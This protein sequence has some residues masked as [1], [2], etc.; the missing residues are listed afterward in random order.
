MENGVFLGEDYFEQLLME[1]PSRLST[2]IDIVVEPGT[3]VDEYI[4]RA[5]VIFPFVRFEEHVRV[6]KNKIEK[7]H[8]Q[9]TQ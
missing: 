4:R 2:D 1:S 9:S 3:P 5:S 8:F 6:G 7:R